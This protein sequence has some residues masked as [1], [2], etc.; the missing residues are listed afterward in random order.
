MLL[1]A[2]LDIDVRQGMTLQAVKGTVYVSLMVNGMPL[3]PV[4][5][6]E[7][8]CNSHEIYIYILQ[9]VLV[10]LLLNTFFLII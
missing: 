7:L 5:H 2:R 9:F 8:V 10:I 3:L 1:E 4:H 6:R